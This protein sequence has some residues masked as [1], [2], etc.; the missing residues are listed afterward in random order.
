[1]NR[2]MEFLQ[3]AWHLLVWW[4]N[5]EKARLLV[6]L[7]MGEV[8]ELYNRIAELETLLCQK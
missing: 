7:T 4:G 3:Q 2:A 8:Q 5:C 6:E 1:M